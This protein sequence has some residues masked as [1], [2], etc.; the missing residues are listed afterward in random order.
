MLY[1]NVPARFRCDGCL[2]MD[3]DDNDLVED[4]ETNFPAIPALDSNASSRA[5]TS[6]R[7]SLSGSVAFDVVAD[8]AMVQ[9]DVSI[10]SFVPVSRG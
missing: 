6:P 5:T 10:V 9:S 7:R 1:T 2:L 4:D 8:G 3:A